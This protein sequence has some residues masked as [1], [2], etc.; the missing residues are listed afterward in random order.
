MHWSQ[1]IFKAIAKRLMAHRFKIWGILSSCWCVMAAMAHT[2]VVTQPALVQIGVSE[3]IR[4]FYSFVLQRETPM[5]MRMFMYQPRM[6][7]NWNQSIF[8]TAEETNINKASFFWKTNQRS[9]AN[10]A[11]K[12]PFYKGAMSL[13]QHIINCYFFQ[14]IK[15]DSC[16]LIGAL[17]LMSV[18]LATPQPV[19]EHPSQYPKGSYCINWEKGCSNKSSMHDF[20]PVIYPST[21]P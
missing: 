16:V 11:Q 12:S 5:Y 15:Q 9:F 6:F 18:P 17:L 19:M 2:G 1:S 3:G 7:G 21:C 8:Q 14:G 13:H 10:L 4:R 20:Y